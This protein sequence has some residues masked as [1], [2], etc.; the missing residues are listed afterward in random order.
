[1]A[2]ILNFLESKSLE[3][4]VL[5]AQAEGGRFG[6]AK[7]SCL[8]CANNMYVCTYENTHV[9]MYV[10]VCVCTYVCHHYGLIGL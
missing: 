9:C 6:S 4:T 2:P 10:C 7:V 1:M 5:K 3:F 8:Y